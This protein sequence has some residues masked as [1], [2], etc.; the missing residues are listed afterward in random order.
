MKG[1][2]QERFDELL[3]ELKSLEINDDQ[4]EAIVGQAYGDVGMTESM[5]KK[6][7]V[8]VLRGDNYWE[9]ITGKKGTNPIRAEKVAGIII[10]SIKKD[11]EP[12]EYQKLDYWDL[13]P[14]I[15]KLL[16]KEL[17]MKDFSF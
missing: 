7:G 5:M 8:R 11:K 17:D 9:L 15:Q 4:I 14:K 3:K 1:K 16:E 12:I 2:H 10:S 6:S 13:I